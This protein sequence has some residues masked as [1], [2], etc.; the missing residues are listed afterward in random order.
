[1]HGTMIHFSPLKNWKPAGMTFDDLV[2][3]SLK[4]HRLTVGVFTVTE[5]YFPL[6]FKFLGDLI[7]LNCSYYVAKFMA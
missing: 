7:Q 4:L 1:M 3:T 5:Y 6:R 2:C